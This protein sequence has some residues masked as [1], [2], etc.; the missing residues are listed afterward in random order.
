VSALVEGGVI[1]SCHFKKAK[2]CPVL[3]GQ[4]FTL[5]CYVILRAENGFI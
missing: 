4:P 3:F 1:E 5:L 2:G